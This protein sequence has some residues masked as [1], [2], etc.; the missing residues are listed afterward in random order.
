MAEPLHL[1][2]QLA[3]LRRQAGRASGA[4]GREWSRRWPKSLA[5]SASGRSPSS[6]ELFDSVKNW[7]RWGPDDTRGTLNYITPEHVRSAASLVRTGRSIS[8]S[9][10]VNKVAGPD[11]P[12]PGHP[13]HGDRPRQ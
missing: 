11:N 2:R 4:L 6:T 9:L 5:R 8:L 10:P 7:G 13:L 1:S 12:T 3:S